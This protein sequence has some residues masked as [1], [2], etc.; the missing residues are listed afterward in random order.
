MKKYIETL[1][2][3]IED[4]SMASPEKASKLLQTIYSYVRFSKTHHLKQNAR[5]V[6][7]YMI[8]KVA[9]GIADSFKYPQNWLSEV[10]CRS[11]RRQ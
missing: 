1:G 10:V 3:F 5:T 11:S 7:D 9:G 6:Y 4:L 2:S 8:G